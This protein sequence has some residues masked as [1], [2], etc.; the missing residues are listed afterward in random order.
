MKLQKTSIILL[1]CSLVL[2]SIYGDARASSIGSTSGASKDN[3]A[4]RPTTRP[5]V[6]IPVTIY[7]EDGNAS[8][9]TSDKCIVPYCTVHDKY[10]GNEHQC[11]YVK[12]EG[13][14]AD[15]IM[16]WIGILTVIFLVFVLCFVCRY[17]QG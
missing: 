12:P 10:C 16:A 14:V 5:G 7:D 8:Q 9:S 6:I 11:T 1:L 4:D 2:L 17:F 15:S 13:E 3:V